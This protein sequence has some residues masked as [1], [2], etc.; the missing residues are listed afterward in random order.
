MSRAEDEGIEMG[1]PAPLAEREFAKWSAQHVPTCRCDV[2]VVGVRFE[3][4]GLRCGNCDAV[5]LRRRAA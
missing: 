5:I 1:S 3:V 4:E 2:R